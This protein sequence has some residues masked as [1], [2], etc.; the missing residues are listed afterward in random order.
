MRRNREL[1]DSFTPF[2]ERYIHLAV[3]QSCNAQKVGEYFIS[4]SVDV[5]E[6]DIDI[7]R[8]ELIQT[9]RCYYYDSRQIPT[10]LSIVS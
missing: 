6:G 3:M 7:D 9:R 1:T 5:T 4:T 2:F 8:S 10:T